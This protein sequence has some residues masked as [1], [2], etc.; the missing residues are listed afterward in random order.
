MIENRIALSTNLPS[1]NRGIDRLLHIAK[2]LVDADAAAV[3]MTQSGVKHCIAESGLASGIVTVPWRW[4]D[5]P[6]KPNQTFVQQSPTDLNISRLLAATTGQSSVGLFVRLPLVV[7]ENYSLALQ[8]Y[9]RENKKVPS[10]SDLRLLKQVGMAIKR[11]IAHDMT[12][13]ASKDSR[14]SIRATSAEM[15]DEVNSGDGL[16]VLLDPDFRIVSISKSLALRLDRPQQDLI[17]ERYFQV[18]R[19]SAESLSHL[20]RKVIDSSISSPILQ[21]V[22]ATD[23]LIRNYSLRASPFRPSDGDVD[24]LDVH[25]WEGRHGVEKPALA[26]SKLG[27]SDSASDDHDTAGQ[28]L[29]DT[30][31]LK[32][33]L[34]VREDTTYFTIRA[35]RHSIRQ[36]QIKALRAVK[37]APLPDFVRLVARECATEIHRLVGV[38]S[39]QFVVPI[40]CGHSPEETC[41]SSALAKAIGVELALPV[42]QAFPHLQ[43][44]GSSHPKEN[45][46]RDRMRQVQ[47]V[48]GPAI[49]ID[50][51]ATSGV[52]LGEASS[53]LKASGTATFAV[54][55]L[56]GDAVGSI[57]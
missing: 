28:F 14:V 36:H 45:L 50:D 25:F 57:V 22:V 47:A 3:L 13:I 4:N 43:Q 32:R 24:M 7:T 1:F 29:L 31:V 10:D 6:F 35:W 5:L 26:S 52:H 38:N 56:G 39:F 33:S 27:L 49:L 53:L 15:S 34:R 54:A 42:I 16:R 18:I 46:K 44:K 20:F 21:I 17:G 19:Q 40:P 11:E 37:K 30:L 12:L 55:W 8:L 48:P 9:S 2:V 23:G 41:M 51:V